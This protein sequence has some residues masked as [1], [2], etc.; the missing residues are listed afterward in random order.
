MQDACIDTRSNY[1]PTGS[2]SCGAAGAA[3]DT[4][5]STCEAVRDGGP[6]GTW[7]TASSVVKPGSSAA[8]T[9]FDSGNVSVGWLG[10][11]KREDKGVFLPDPK[12]KQKQTHPFPP[13]FILQTLFPSQVC[14]STSKAYFYIQWDPTLCPG[15]QPPAP[16]LVAQ[17]GANYKGPS[18]KRKGES[19]TQGRAPATAYRGGDVSS[20]Q[21][22]GGFSFWWAI[23]IAAG[24][25]GMCALVAVLARRAAAKPPPVVGTGGGPGVQMAGVP[26]PPPPSGGAGMMAGGPPPPGAYVPGGAPPPPPAVGGAG[27]GGAGGVQYS[28]APAG[29]AAGGATPGVPL[30]GATDGGGKPPGVGGGYPKI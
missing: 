24:I 15:K 5:T 13:P 2:P 9:A 4:S 25:L 28:F 18:C 19:M 3:A 11:K 30:T 27:A 17:T 6:P 7:I 20:T 29:G 26:P 1:F 14:T 22:K 23:L 21:K 12:Q 8:A 16:R 10:R